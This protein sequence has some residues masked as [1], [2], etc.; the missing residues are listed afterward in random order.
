MDFMPQI[1]GCGLL[2]I[3]AAVFLISLRLFALEKKLDQ[4]IGVLKNSQG[5][6]EQGTQG[7]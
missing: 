6:H 7:Q 3:A 1:I 4:L 5:K 2:A